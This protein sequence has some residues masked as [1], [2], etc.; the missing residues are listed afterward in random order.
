[1]IFTYRIP[2]KFFFSEKALIFFK[3]STKSQ[4]KQRYIY[5]NFW[6]WSNWTSK[7][8]TIK[9]LNSKRNRDKR[10][11][12]WRNLDCYQNQFYVIF[13]LNFSISIPNKLRNIYHFTH[14]F[15][16]VIQTAL[17]HGKRI[18]W[19]HLESLYDKNLL[20]FS[21]DFIANIFCESIRFNRL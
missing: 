9:Y 4:L 19:I 20:D 10:V 1:M 12:F 11:S 3:I 21:S 17:H 2:W 18:F 8:L 14:S 6:D 7:K 5:F 13:L 16:R 15:N